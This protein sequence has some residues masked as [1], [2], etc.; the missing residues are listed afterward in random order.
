MPLTYHDAW[1]KT[2]ATPEREARAF[3]DVDA[4]A[5]FPTEWRDRLAVLRTYELVC[6]ECQANADDLFAQKLKHYRAE[7]QTTLTQARAALPS[8]A[9]TG[10]AAVFSITLER[11]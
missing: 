10:G 3:A 2:H 5:A 8:A 4:I 7:W 1:L 9:A 11:A 6:L